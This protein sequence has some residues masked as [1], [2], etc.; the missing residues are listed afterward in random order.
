MY[1]WQ[2]AAT[3]SAG[4]RGRVA[5]GTKLVRATGVS[6]RAWSLTRCVPFQIC[7]MRL[8]I[9]VVCV[10]RVGCA[11][12]QVRPAGQRCGPP[13]DLSDS[14]P[15]LSLRSASATTRRQSPSPNRLHVCMHALN[16]ETPATGSAHASS[17]SCRGG[18]FAF[19]LRV[20]SE[21]VLRKVAACP[22]GVPGALLLALA[23]VFFAFRH[24]STRRGESAG[25]QKAA[26]DCTGWVLS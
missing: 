1:T 17:H 26:G 2:P 15:T 6:R 9:V 14:T 16:A 4:M 23:I 25:Q 11:V 19:A 7:G 8:G 18:S 3:A 22:L 24:S 10:V 12:E 5:S 21:C 20:W 13:G